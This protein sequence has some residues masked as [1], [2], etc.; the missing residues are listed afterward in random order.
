LTCSELSPL[1][2]PDYGKTLSLLTRLPLPL[3]ELT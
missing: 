1:A 2:A 3:K